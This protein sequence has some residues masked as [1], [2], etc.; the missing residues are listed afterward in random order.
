MIH[1]V[2]LTSITERFPIAE[3]LSSLADS[4]LA[5]AYAIFKKLREIF[6]AEKKR[7]FDEIHFFCGNSQYKGISIE[8]LNSLVSIIEKMNTASKAILCS[9]ADVIPSN[10]KPGSLFVFPG[11][12]CSE[13]DELLSGK[14]QKQLYQWVVKGGR[15]LGICAGSYYCSAKSEYRTANQKAILR[16]RKIAL[17]PGTC[18]GPVYSSMLKVVKVRWEKT[19]KEGY[20]TVIGRGFYRQ[21]IA[22]V[23]L[24][25]CWQDIPIVPQKSPSRW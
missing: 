24:M 16:S 13:W 17:F 15:I 5:A 11:G 6:S 3:T 14:Q 20:V 4:I 1:C 8:S 21:K 19:Q 7:A 9:H 18:R 23:H 10:W 12:T 2:S 25:K 22:T